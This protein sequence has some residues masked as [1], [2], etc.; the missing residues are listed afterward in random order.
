MM[1]LMAMMAMQMFLSLVV[2]FVPCGVFYGTDCF[3]NE[4][5]NLSHGLFRLFHRTE[6]K[7]IY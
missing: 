1:M 6:Q 5:K 3:L 7:T 2:G 4:I